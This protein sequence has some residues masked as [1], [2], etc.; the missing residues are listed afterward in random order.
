MF[1]WMEGLVAVLHRP[2]VNWLFLHRDRRFLI[3]YKKPHA[4][5]PLTHPYLYKK[6]Y[7]F[8]YFHV[9]MLL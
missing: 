1:N 3:T 4:A 2:T 6:K 5:Q 7:I 8:M 9:V